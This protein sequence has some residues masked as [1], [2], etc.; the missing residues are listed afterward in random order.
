LDGF[1]MPLCA[2]CLGIHVGFLISAVVIWLQKGRLPSDGLPGTRS[3]IILGLMMAPAVADVSLSY[4]DVIESDNARRAVTGA[5]FGTCLAF[6]ILP[7]V[8][9][10]VALSAVALLASAAVL[11]AES[12]EVLFYSIAVAGVTGVF[13]TTWSLI[14]MLTLLL[15]EDHAWSK[16]M[17][18]TL[19]TIAT[20][21]FLLSMAAL[22]A[23]VD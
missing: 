16:K 23:L 15:T 10:W 22:H 20:P 12:S 4:L 5:L 11:S 13:A 21:L 18:L 1:Q 19:A 8:R 17:K 3:L 9:Y 6:I 2:R 14:A 7:F